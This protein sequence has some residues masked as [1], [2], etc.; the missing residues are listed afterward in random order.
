MELESPESRARA[1]RKRIDREEN[2]KVR[3]AQDD[4]AA[5]VV[6]EAKA[7]EDARNVA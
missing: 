6:A 5:S 3:L 7:A 1:L 4:A 2:E